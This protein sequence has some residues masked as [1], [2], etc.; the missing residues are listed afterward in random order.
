MRLSLL[1]EGFSSWGGG[2]DLLRFL[3]TSIA[4]LPPPP[5]S[6]RQLILPRDDLLFQAT[7]LASPLKRLFGMALAGKR[8]RWQPW[9]GFPE[10]YCRNAFA[11]LEKD[12]R[13]D[14]AGRLPGQQL[15]AARRFDADIVL[16]LFNPPPKSWKKPW[17]GYLYDFQHRHFPDFFTP[18]ARRARDRHF[19][20]MLHRAE[21]VIVN[22]RTVAEDAARFMG[23]FPARLHVLP[24]SPCPER[25]WLED[26][27]DARP[28]YR[29]DKPFFMVCNQ[30]WKH[31]D[32][33]TAFRGFAR[34]LH[35]GGEA[36]LVCTGATSDHRFPEYRSEL[37]TLVDKLGIRDHLRIL[38]HI[39]KRTQI[40]L[41]K[42]ALAL[43]Q[44]TL[45]EG[46]PGGGGA[47]DAISLGIP[48][49]VSDIPVNREMACGELSYFTPGDDEALARRLCDRGTGA[50]IAPDPLRLWEE[51]MVRKQRCG[52]TLLELASGMLA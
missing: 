4:T 46:G 13:I 36:L 7:R 42:Q 43:I 17:I 18:G 44:P 32:H 27:R 34:F 29:I 50:T 2:L 51:G 21:Q 6:Y 31:K 40:G 26:D 19:F 24:F 39:P 49:I 9:Q 37:Q 23:A 16:P 22:A 20:E 48:V 30:F 28:D 10:V 41:L 1:S 25:G 47:F 14:F 11:D 38:G 8:P 52:R 3:A 15:A 33:P 5:G 35:Q 12:F 45:F